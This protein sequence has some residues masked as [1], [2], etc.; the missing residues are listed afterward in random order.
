MVLT[1]I[2]FHP[3]SESIQRGNEC[4]TSENV[5]ECARIYPQSIRSDSQIGNAIVFRHCAKTDSSGVMQ[6]FTNYSN[7]KAGARAINVVE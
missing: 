6:T 4:G 3:E 7:I 1:N 5:R 2:S